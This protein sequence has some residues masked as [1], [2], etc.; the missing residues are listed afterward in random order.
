[1]PNTTRAL[2]AHKLL[3][4]LAQCLYHHHLNC[5]L[6][7]LWKP[8]NYHMAWTVLLQSW[9]ILVVV[10]WSVLLSRLLPVCNECYQFKNGL[11]SAMMRTGLQQSMKWSFG[12]F[13]WWGGWAFHPCYINMLALYC[14]YFLQELWELISFLISE[15][16]NHWWHQSKPS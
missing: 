11:F 10:S 13:M 5:K 3:A 4:K 6:P 2:K 15:Q 8:V 12:N 7:S 14:N 9:A 16:N 1:M